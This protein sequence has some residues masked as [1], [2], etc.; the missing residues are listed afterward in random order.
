MST[1]AS[2]WPSL[3]ARSF[4]TLCRSP[5]KLPA[6]SP[7]HNIIHMATL[8]IAHSLLELFLARRGKCTPRTNASVS[9]MA[10]SKDL[11]DLHRCRHWSYCRTGIG[12]EG[13]GSR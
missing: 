3:L 1:A 7:P 2:G 10:E 6:S 8:R 5:Y 4:E 11:K 12:S 9:Y 13:C